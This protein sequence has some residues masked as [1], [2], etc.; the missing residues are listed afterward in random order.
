MA[1]SKITPTSLAAGAARANFGAGAV[2]QVLQSVTSTT[3][4]STSTSYADAS[5]LSV[6]IT[7]TSPT[8]KFLILCDL[9]TFI[10][11]DNSTGLGIR[12]MRDSTAIYTND[13]FA[14]NNVNANVGLYKHESYNYL[15]SPATA[16]AITYKVQLK[17]TSS[18]GTSY[19]V[20]I[21]ASSSNNISSITVLE[22]AA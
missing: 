13:Y 1:I 20:A 22:I 15:D 21:N 3:T 6:T 5:N 18:A 10:Q 2:L 9:A 8:S 7:P 12:L 11:A 4:S 16:S 19:A 14:F 17:R